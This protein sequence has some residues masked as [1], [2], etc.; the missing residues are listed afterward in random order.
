[1]EPLRRTGPPG[2]EVQML[3]RDFWGGK[4]NSVLLTADV[5][6][7]IGRPISVRKH[8]KAGRTVTRWNAFVFRHSLIYVV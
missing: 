3:S 7:S 4:R 5:W 2:P 1:M 8:N 6:Y